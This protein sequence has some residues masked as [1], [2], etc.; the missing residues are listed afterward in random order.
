[1]D[2]WKTADPL[3]VAGTGQLVVAAGDDGRLR[4]FNYPCVVDGAPHRQVHSAKMKHSSCLWH[5]QNASQYLGTAVMYDW[6]TAQLHRLL[7]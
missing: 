3:A 5:C 1:M 4:L 7:Y 6:S 2:G